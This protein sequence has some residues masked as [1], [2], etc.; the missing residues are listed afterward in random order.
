MIVVVREGDTRP[1][2]IVSEGVTSVC[3]Y[4]GSGALVRAVSVIPGSNVMLTA[5]A[6]DPDFA[7]VIKT[8]GIPRTQDIPQR[9]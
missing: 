1:P 6:G 5:T 3:F 7:Q 4:D 8:L 2:T 9:K